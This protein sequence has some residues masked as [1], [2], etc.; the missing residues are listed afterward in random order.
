MQEDVSAVSQCCSNSS[1]KILSNECL[2]KSLASVVR[3]EVDSLVREWFGKRDWL[4]A[5]SVS[6]SSFVVIIVRRTF[7]DVTSEC[8]R[9]RGFRERQSLRSKSTAGEPGDK[10]QSLELDEIVRRVGL[11]ERGHLD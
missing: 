11:L 5:G 3:L 2:S 4:V 8:Q 6:T 7:E 9:N 1:T 10:A